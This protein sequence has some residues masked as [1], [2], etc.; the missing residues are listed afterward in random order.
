[1]LHVPRELAYT[2]SY[3]CNTHS[4]ERDLWNHSKFG[5]HA[6]YT[7]NFFLKISTEKLLFSAA[8]VCVQYLTLEIN[9][10]LEVFEEK[11]CTSFFT[12]YLML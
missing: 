9:I 3:E 4:R 12:D 1:M 10:I 5:S 7:I 6:I 2:L 8:E 11:K